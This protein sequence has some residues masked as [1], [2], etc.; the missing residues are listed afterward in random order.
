VVGLHQETSKQSDLEKV[1]TD[2]MKRANN[3]SRFVKGFKRIAS[4]HLVGFIGLIIIT[5]LFF[6]AAKSISYTGLT[7]MD[8]RGFQLV[9]EVSDRTDFRLVGDCVDESGLATS[10]YLIDDMAS[11]ELV[12]DLARW[13]IAGSAWTFQIGGV[14]AFSADDSAITFNLPAYDSPYYIYT[15]PGSWS[16]PPPGWDAFFRDFGTSKLV[17]F[18]IGYTLHKDLDALTLFFQQY[19]DKERIDS[20]SWG[21]PSKKGSNTFTE[22]VEIHPEAK[23]FRVYLRFVNRTQNEITLESLKLINMHGYNLLLTGIEN[24][25]KKLAF[26]LHLSGIAECPGFIVFKKGPELKSRSGYQNLRFFVSVETGDLDK[27]LLSFLK[28]KVFLDEALVW[29]MPVSEIGNPTFVEQNIEFLNSKE[30]SEISFNVGCD[31]L[32]SAQQKEIM[33]QS[34]DISIEYLDIR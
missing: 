19:D 15:F 22:R 32:D 12:T 18:E 30:L 3:R 8:M 29:S 14:T 7:L 33:D 26:T 2:E 31:S 1:I 6:A 10:Y 21:M 27:A 28:I 16:A 23:S 17:E 24:N 4:A 20:I 5:A 34:I 13:D 25:F 11:K 9:E